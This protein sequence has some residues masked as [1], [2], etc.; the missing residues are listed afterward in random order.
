MQHAD[1]DLLL[2]PGSATVQ[3][4]PIGAIGRSERPKWPGVGTF[5]RFASANLQTFRS[6]GR[7]ERS[8]RPIERLGTVQMNL[9]LA[10]KC[11]NFR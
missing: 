5:P 3:M 4:R 1:V 9:E 2:V 7:P 8:D 6:F 11:W 10:N